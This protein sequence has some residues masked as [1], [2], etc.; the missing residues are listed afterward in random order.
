MWGN[1]VKWTGL[2]GLAACI[3]CAPTGKYSALPAPPMASPTQKSTQSVDLQSAADATD[4]DERRQALV[5]L[6]METQGLIE[7]GMSVGLIDGDPI[8]RIPAYLFFEEDQAQL[9]TDAANVLALLVNVL[10]DR[11]DT[12]FT[13]HAH[14]PRGG[15]LPVLEAARGLGLLNALVNAGLP[16]SQI[17]V[18]GGFYL[19]LRNQ[20][21]PEH[22]ADDNDP[23][24]NA[25]HIR[26]TPRMTN[27]QRTVS[28]KTKAQV[29]K[30]TEAKN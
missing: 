14:G 9:N 2:F 10:M 3:A 1:T 25:L 26:F 27:Q 18:A 16:V 11:K 13:L 19:E 20:I 21:G 8:I 24:D 17:E 30:A 23:H 7:A 29:L 15:T 28:S 4:L 6:A 12:H 5:Q 22:A